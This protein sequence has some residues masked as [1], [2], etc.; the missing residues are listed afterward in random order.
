MKY[1]ASL[2]QLL[3]SLTVVSKTFYQ[4]SSGSKTFLFINDFMQALPKVPCGNSITVVNYCALLCWL[5][6]DVQ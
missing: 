5:L 2:N 3:K 6:E 4:T 1:Q